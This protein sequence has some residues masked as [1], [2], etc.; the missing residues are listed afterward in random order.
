MRECLNNYLYSSVHY[1]N[2]NGDGWD[3]TQYPI[4][5]FVSEYGFQSMPSMYTWISATENQSDLELDSP[6]MK[7]RQ[8]L[9]NGWNFM[10]EQISQ[11]FEIPLSS[12]SARDLMDFVYLSQIT[13]AVAIRVQ[14]ESYRQMKSLLNERGE[15]MTMGAL[16]WQLNDVWQAP[17]WS[18]IGNKLIL[19][20]WRWFRHEYSSEFPQILRDAGKCF[21][22]MPRNFSLLWSWRHVLMRTA[23]LKYILCPICFK[24]WQIWVPLLFFTSG[25]VQ[26]LFIL[27]DWK[28]WLWLVAI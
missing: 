16:Y 21:T 7:H 25:K 26:G 15:G 24:I 5:R 1:Y 28:M 22:I 4:A 6:F 18:S 27:F 17:S 8:H 11:N 20:C 3:V 14:T 19:I 12:N 10:R 2:Y 23:S 13:Q 9:N